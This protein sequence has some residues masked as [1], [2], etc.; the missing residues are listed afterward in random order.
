MDVA[1]VIPSLLQTNLTDGLDVYKRQVC[2]FAAILAAG[3]LVTGGAGWLWLAVLLS[4][5]HI[6]GGGV[7][8]RAQ[9]V[10]EQG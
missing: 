1:A 3:W 10:P 6:Y 7:P 8:E 5:I 4:L 2:T 9:P